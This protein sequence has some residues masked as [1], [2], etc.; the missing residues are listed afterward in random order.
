MGCTNC[1]SNEHNKVS[2]TKKN[3]I[4]EEHSIILDEAIKN[5]LRNLAYYCQMVANE[6]GKGYNEKVYQEALGI[7]LQYN[8]ILHCQEEV[9]PITYKN[10]QVGGNHSIRIDICIQREYLDFIYE[11]KATNSQLQSAELNQL[12]RYLTFKK[13]NYGAIINFNQS[14]IGKLEIQFIIKH[15]N[16]YYLYNILTNKGKIF[17]NFSLESDVDYNPTEEVDVVH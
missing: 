7:E 14:S 15:N 1:G 9:L 11:L 4:P 10:I 5:K 3:I 16:N 13:Y 6:L 2:C 8:R 12:V 17:N